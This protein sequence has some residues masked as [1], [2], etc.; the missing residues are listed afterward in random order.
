[1]KAMFFPE[2]HRA[3]IVERAV[4][5]P[6]RGEVLVR[7]RAAGICAS[8]VAAFQ[9]KH[10]VRRPP[11]ITGHELAGEIAMVGPGATGWAV[12]DRVA[13][14]PH[15]GC[16]A[17]A[18]CRRGQYHECPEKRF[19]G[20]GDWIGA[21]AEYVVAAGCMCHRMPSDMTYD[22]GAVLE[23]FCVGL[24][25]VRRGQPQMGDRIAILGGG[26][27]GL[28]T[29]LAAGLTGPDQVIVS[30]PSAAKRG[31]AST[32]GATATIDPRSQNVVEEIQRATD[33][34]G[35]DLVFVAVSVPEVLRQGL[36]ACRRIGKLVIV[37]SFFDE[38]AINARQ[39]Q[40]RER[41]IIGTSMYT[42]DDYRLAIS[43]WKAGRLDLRPLISDR[44][45]LSDAPAAVADLA[46]GRRPDAVKIVIGFP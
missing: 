40:V 16:G 21:F 41:T 42:A 3:E 23:P 7:V 11:V 9:G 34:L 6:G 39:V 46:R 38:T 30:E 32:C 29:L 14:E 4:P 13:V 44:I 36:D 12:G 28:M 1:M 31:V 19:V 22:E 18:Y 10:N 5:N 33:G 24:H 15:M 20:V 37:A 17:C 45:G 8:D 2:P 35:A 43:L 25:A 27:I 26:T